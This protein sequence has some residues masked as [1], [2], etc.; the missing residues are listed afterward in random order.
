MLLPFFSPLHWNI[1]NKSFA[2]RY[3]GR[4]LCCLNINASVLAKYHKVEAN[5][6]NE[7]KRAKVRVNG[8]IV[9]LSFMDQ[10]DLGRIRLTNR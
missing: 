5:L 8:T 9:C 6:F 2:S 1:V 7:R 4:F 10:A 3:S